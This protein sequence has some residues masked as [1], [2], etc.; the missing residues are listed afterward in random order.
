MNYLS[1]KEMYLANI[2]NI[3]QIIEQ[4]SEL[5]KIDGLKLDVSYYQNEVNTI[6]KDAKDLSN[7]E[8]HLIPYHLYNDRLNY[9]IKDINEEAKSLNNIRLY[10]CKINDL[11]K[12]INK[13]NFIETISMTK[14]L[15]N[16]ILDL[17][18]NHINADAII[19][20][21]YKIIYNVLLYGAMVGNY[22]LLNFSP[23]IN[24]DVL[25][26]HLGSLIQGDL[27]KLSQEEL[28]D[29][30]M[31]YQD[32]DLGYDYLDSDIIDKICS[33]T[34][35]DKY[36]EFINNKKSASFF[37]LEKAD[38]L[39]K[40]RDDFFK[41]KKERKDKISSYRSDLAL[42]RLKFYALLL[43]PIIGLTSLGFLGS[44][45]NRK[46]KN[47]IRRFDAYTNKTLDE[48]QTWYEDLKYA[49]KAEIIKY[50]P[51]RVNLA[52]D[53]YVRDVMEVTYTSKELSEN[54]DFEELLKSINNRSQYL[55]KKKKLDSGDS[56]TEPEMVV[57]E[58]VVDKNDSYPYVEAIVLFPL[59]GLGI[60]GIIDCVLNHFDKEYFAK[61]KE[62]YRDIENDKRDLR[63]EKKGKITRKVIVKRLTEIGNKTVELQ[64]EY[65]K[66]IDKYGEIESKIDPELIENAKRY[67]LTR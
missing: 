19:N 27:Q 10:S 32:K 57:T 21:S 45:I 35:G 62:T 13:S 26:E 40:E 56:M 37:L 42:S 9:L 6:L 5:D 14:E 46:T 52:G 25:R 63:K 61:L 41:E 22:D 51:W 33:I 55:Q 2:M 65:S 15:I 28:L 20:N 36:D 44:A 12:D 66:T 64:E 23:I 48:P 30:K 59:V 8:M 31:K 34:L 43:V 53:G 11:L 24:N 3:N 18:L 38:K 7:N 54:I 4:L 16:A 50:G 29:I 58:T 60:L 67:V 1:D 17:K 49:Y 47:T 39:K